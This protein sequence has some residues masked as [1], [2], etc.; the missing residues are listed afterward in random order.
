MV[1]SPGLA[2]K[3]VL[4][5]QALRLEQDVKD[6][7]DQRRSAVISK[8][9]N[10]AI[11]SQAILKHQDF[12]ELTIPVSNAERRIIHDRYHRHVAKAK[13]DLDT[14]IHR[15]GISPRKAQ[16]LYQGS[17]NDAIR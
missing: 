10:Q 5:N 2:F 14:N 3:A 1:G 4:I 17:I 8:F 9:C 11:Q 12:R 6:A 7:I 15:Y 13:L 16:K